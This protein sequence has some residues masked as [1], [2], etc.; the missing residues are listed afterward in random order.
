MR[1]LIGFQKEENKENVEREYWKTSL[2]KKIFIVEDMSPQKYSL[3]MSNRINKN[4]SLCKYVNQPQD[5]KSKEG[6][7]HLAQ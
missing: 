2:L 7:S 6:A 4:V 5:I 1:C 3:S